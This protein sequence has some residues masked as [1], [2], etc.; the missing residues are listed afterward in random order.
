MTNLVFVTKRMFRVRDHQIKRS[1]IEDIQIKKG[2]LFDRLTIRTSG[3]QKQFYFFKDA[4]N[5]GSHAYEILK[6]PLGKVQVRF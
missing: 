2:L 5:R 3:K 1:A 4:A 6:R